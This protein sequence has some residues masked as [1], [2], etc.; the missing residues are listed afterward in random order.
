MNNFNEYVSNIN[1]SYI[2]KRCGYNTD[3]KHSII[4]HMLRKNICK[5][6]YSK[7]YK[8]LIYEKKCEFKCKYCNIKFTLKRN[9]NK[10]LKKS[11]KKYK[12]SEYSMRLAHQ[13]TNTI[14]ITNNTIN[15]YTINNNINIVVKKDAFFSTIRFT[16]RYLLKRHRAAY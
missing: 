12:N 4:K 8:N 10:H 15:N 16:Q 11:C 1:S 2:C 7:K 9:L 3:Y 14:N 5:S 13:S 6:I